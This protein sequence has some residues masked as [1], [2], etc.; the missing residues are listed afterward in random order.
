MAD[1]HA[2]GDV[3]DTPVAGAA[4]PRRDPPDQ[5]LARAII[6]PLVRTRVT[7][8]H[9]TTVR[10]ALGLGA[11]AAYAT[12]GVH[13]F[14]IG[15]VLF[16]LSTLMDHA[17]G[18][19]ARMS[20]KTSRIGHVYDLFADVTVQVLLFVAIGVGLMNAGHGTVMLA[21]GLIAGGSVSAL[22]M[23]CQRLE[24]RI[25][26]KQAGLPRP[27]GFDMEDALYLIAPITWIGWLQFLLIAAAIA[28]PLFL[29][30]LLWHHRRVIF[31]RAI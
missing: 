10:L 28:A 14:M 5:R 23:V 12:G 4:L 7:P 26:G 22:F 31:A 3:S 29:F 24:A 15:S 9:L 13:W 17:D 6:R 25:G 8:N 2:R 1:I 18:E 19:L 27:G 20:G 16:L 11:C 30:W 21:L